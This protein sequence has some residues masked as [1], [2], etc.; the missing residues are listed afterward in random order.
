ML[1]GY[2]CSRTRAPAPGDPVSYLGLWGERCSAGA[3]ASSHP[4]FVPLREDPEPGC[5]P[6]C[7]VLTAG[8]A[9]GAV[10]PIRNVLS[11]ETPRPRWWATLRSRFS[12]LRF[13]I[14]RVPSSFAEARLIRLIKPRAGEE[15]QRSLKS[16]GT[17]CHLWASPVPGAWVESRW[18]SALRRNL[19]FTGKQSFP[20]RQRLAAA[21]FPRAAW[22]PGHPRG[23]E[24]PAGLP[25]WAGTTR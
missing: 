25:H 9:A 21:L 2:D 11:A 18:V 14:A 20:G 13:P 4:T 7:P 10:L 24:S 8:P 12:G 23:S 22:P 15:S 1:R 3:T 16:K 5:F 19:P 6:A 17:R